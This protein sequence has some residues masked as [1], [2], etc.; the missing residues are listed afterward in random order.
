MEILNKDEFFSLSTYLNLRDL[1]NFCRT[2]KYIRDILYRD[3][4][5]NYR[6][7]KEFPEYNLNIQESKKDVYKLLY[8][9]TILKNKLRL[10][11]TI[12]ELYNLK[13]LHLSSQHEQIPKQIGVLINLKRLY[14]TN[15]R[16]TQLPK[17]LGNLKN[18]ELFNSTDNML[19][20]IP[21]ELGNLINLKYLALSFN[22]IEE[23]PKELGNLTNLESLYL[24]DNKLKDLPKEF[25]KLK[26][27][28]EIY[29]ARNKSAWLGKC[30]L[31]H[32]NLKISI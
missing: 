10:K 17:E 2:N 15:N 21:K 20:K 5:W 13:E 29:L 26:N 3:S 24:N 23:I 25:S 6:L 22:E 1:L 8:S 16:L 14:L 9:I 12:Y 19:T 11:Q 30:F 4:V 27:L 32:K 31:Q 18:L 28:K 7:K